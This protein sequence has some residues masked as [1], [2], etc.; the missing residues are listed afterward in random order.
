M[1]PA[2]SR[3]FPG[4]QRAS[5]G[6]GRQAMRADDDADTIQLAYQAALDSSLWPAVLQRLLDMFD[7]HCGSF[8]C[9]R[10]DGTGGTCIELG[11]DPKALEQFFGYYAGRNVLLARGG[12]HPAGTIVSDL[13]R[14]QDL[15]RSSYDRNSP[16]PD[17]DPT[18]H[19]G[20]Q[21]CQRSSEILERPVISP[22]TPTGRCFQPLPP[23]SSVSV[24]T[25]SII[26]LSGARHAW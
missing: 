18:R 7:G 9:R 3:I 10:P 25:R 22:L 16:S 14:P 4:W 17:T 11:F 2:L 6:R 13:R 15:N 21:V 24:V 12:R 23:A 26:F 1:R 20:E 8:I 19:E 5:G